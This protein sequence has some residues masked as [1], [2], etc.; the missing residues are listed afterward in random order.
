MENV[1]LTRNILKQKSW[2]NYLILNQWMAEKVQERQVYNNNVSVNI[3]KGNLDNFLFQSLHTTG[4]AVVEQWAQFYNQDVL[5]TKE[6]SLRISF[7]GFWILFLLGPVSH[8]S[9]SRCKHK[10]NKLLIVYLSHLCTFHILD[11]ALIR[12]D[13]YASCFNCCVMYFDITNLQQCDFF[14]YPCFLVIFFFLL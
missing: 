11:W 8:P 1:A 4:L 10:C 6:S 7:E 5:S 9:L 2:E 3:Q 14:C 12:E 13:W